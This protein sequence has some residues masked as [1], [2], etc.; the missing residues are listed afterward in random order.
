MDLAS[1]D[2]WDAYT[3]AKEGIFLHTDTAEA[4]WTV[5][6]SNDKKRARLE[7]MRHVLSR[8]DYPEKDHGIVGEP[9][10]LIVGR[11]HDILEVEEDGGAPL[12]SWVGQP[13]GVPTS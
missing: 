10:P 3:A 5:V 13:A 7:A 2:K 9:D 11:G 6:K 12:H 8:F 4:P 1:L